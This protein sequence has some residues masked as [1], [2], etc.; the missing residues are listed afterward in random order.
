MQTMQPLSVA[1]QPD[2]SDATPDGGDASDETPVG[3]DASDAN[4]QRV[5]W[6]YGESLSFFFWHFSC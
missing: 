5:N 2:A 4:R 6:K 1:M 3:G